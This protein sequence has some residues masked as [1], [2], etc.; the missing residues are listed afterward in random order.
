M[1]RGAASD[2]RQQIFE[3]ADRTLI[4]TPVVW[5]DHRLD[6]I[7]V[8]MPQKGT[9]RRP[10]HRLAANGPVLLGNVCSG[11]LAAP[12]RNDNG[13]HSLGHLTPYFDVPCFIACPWASE[14][15]CRRLG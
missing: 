14:R 13:S 8:R 4:S 2:R 5:I 7:D 9:Q 15:F 11:A 10:D 6:E 1:P 3:T 12:R